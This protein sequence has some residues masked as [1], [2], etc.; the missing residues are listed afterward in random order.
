MGVASSTVSD[1][2]AVRSSQ[3]CRRFRQPAQQAHTPLPGQAQRE[4][5]PCCQL[6][7]AAVCVQLLH[8]TDA[9]ARLD[10][11]Y[12]QQ[13]QQKQKQHQHTGAERAA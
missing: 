5:A 8:T 2:S 12:Q 4:G 7:D 6:A 13:Q 9:S 3:K 10:M 1:V 11:Q